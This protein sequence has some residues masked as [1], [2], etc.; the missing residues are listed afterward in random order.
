MSQKQAAEQI[1]AL[2][3]KLN[4]MAAA[5][6]AQGDWRV[7]GAEGDW[8]VVSTQSE[9]GDGYEIGY[10]DGEYEI[11]YIERMEAYHRITTSSFE[12]LTYETALAL[13]QIVA[14]TA[15]QRQPE[16]FKD[17]RR[18]I[19]AAELKLLSRLSPGWR[20]Q[21]EHEQAAE[22]KK[23]PFHDRLSGL[24]QLERSEFYYLSNTVNRIMG[25]DR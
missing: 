9:K 8:K 11:R 10:A 6:G 25:R 7:V 21:R 3:E 2:V 18:R 12:D 19:F 24:E 1:G 22:V 23:Q 15:W 13:A 20:D 16:G 4:D 17:P 14:W 5:I